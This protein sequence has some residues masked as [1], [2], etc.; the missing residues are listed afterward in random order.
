MKIHS[1]HLI[2]SFTAV[3]LPATSVAAQSGLTARLQQKLDSLRS[4]QRV[5]GATLGVALR[6][7]TVLQLASGLSDTARKIAMKPSDRLLQGSVGKTYVSAVALQ[8]VHEGKL[9]LDDKISRFFG[10]E[11]WFARLPNGSDITLRQLPE[12]EA[13]AVLP[14]ESLIAVRGFGSLRHV[15]VPSR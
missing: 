14:G 13:G 11:P 15:C 5:P 3:A 4:A 6:D 10:N 12:I 1:I 9:S 7:G 2:V 8:L